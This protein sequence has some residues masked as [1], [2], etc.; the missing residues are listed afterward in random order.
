LQV[1]NTVGPFV[2]KIKVSQP[3]LS[4]SGTPHFHVVPGTPLVSRQ[5]GEPSQ[6][7][8]HLSKTTGIAFHQNLS[9]DSQCS[10]TLEDLSN[11]VTLL[12]GLISETTSFPTESTVVTLKSLI[13]SFG[14]K[15]VRSLDARQSSELLCLLGTISDDGSGRKYHSAWKN[16]GHGWSG[17]D[18]D[19]CWKE[20]VK[21]A[22]VKEKMG[23]VFGERENFWSMRAY[24][25]RLGLV[26]SPGALA[27]ILCL[28]PLTLHL[29]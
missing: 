21:V 12:Q 20:A 18:V 22:E 5:S 28:S 24:L 26:D 15:L 17:L 25:R 16:K 2:Q 1:D 8:I 23:H 29:L 4:N 11:A 19:G 27:H 14:S 3:P 13:R 7:D 6:H 10:V 9:A